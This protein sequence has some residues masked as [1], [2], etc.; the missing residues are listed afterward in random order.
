M[1]V[2]KSFL[3][4][5]YDVA[6]YPHNFPNIAATQV[7]DPSIQN[8]LL[9]CKVWPSRVSCRTT[10][11]CHQSTDGQWKIMIPE[12]L[13]LSMTPFTGIIRLWATLAHLVSMTGCD[14]L[15]C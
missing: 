8:H 9:L 7:T 15:S 13:F 4:Y 10:F 2:L 3:N 11:V 5:P 12:A 1:N 14:L 6:N